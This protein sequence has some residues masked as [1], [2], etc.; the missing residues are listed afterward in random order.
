MGLRGLSNKGL[1]TVLRYAHLLAG[2]LNVLLI[3]TPLGD[4]AQF[5]L[6]V[7]I[8]LVP[9]IVVTGVWMWQQ[10]RVR[11][12]IA[13]VSAK[14]APSPKQ[15]REKFL[16]ELADIHDAEHRFLEAL[17]QMNQ[18]ASDGELRGMIRTHIDQ[19][20][21]QI[22]NLEQVYDQMGQQPER[23]TCR[24]AQGLVAEGQERMR[25]APEGP[26]RDTVIAGAQLKVE[27]YEVA[28][29]RILLSGAQQM[30]Q[31]EVANLLLRN[32]QQEEQ[33]ALLIEQS[34]CP[35]LLQKAMQ[36]A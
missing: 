4:V 1:R 15:I 12:L 36:S 6:L 24:V 14:G 22:K 20:H 26:L 19:T 5:E 3:Y 7:Q 35:R 30:G 25:E 32:L 17:Q 34:I 28:S 9:V 2:V 11:K 21:Q 27:Y 10:A 18:Q 31:H 16:H 13:K 23:Q 8:I 33:T 29:Y